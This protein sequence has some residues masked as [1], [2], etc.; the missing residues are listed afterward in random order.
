MIPVNIKN[1]LFR[2]RLYFAKSPYLKASTMYATKIKTIL[3]FLSISYGICFGASGNED[4]Y[5]QY[6]A[7]PVSERADF[8][9]QIEPFGGYYKHPSSNPKSSTLDTGPEEAA[10]IQLGFK[11]KTEQFGNCVIV[12]VSK[13]RVA[14]EASSLDPD[15]ATCRKYGFIPN[16]NEYAACRLQIDQAKQDAQRQQ[17]QYN[18]QQRQYQAQLDEQKKQRNQA[19]G[20]ALM[21]MGA[22]ISSG[23]YNARNGYG[24]LPTAPTPLESPRT[25]ILPG[26]KAMTCTTTGSVTNCY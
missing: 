23:A 2:I 15:D 18:D 24:T 8:L 3:V 25:Y 17:A 4:Q 14:T 26:G 20:M 7:K 1:K 13:K 19:Q 5:Q 12:L 22:G 6:Y 9:K 21:Q 16:T 11:K 10:C